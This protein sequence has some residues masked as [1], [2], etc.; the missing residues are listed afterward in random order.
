V[1]RVLAQKAVRRLRATQGPLQEFYRR[2]N[3]AWN[4]RD[5]NVIVQLFAEG[6]TYSNPHAGLESIG[7]WA[8]AVWAR[9][10]RLARHGALR[11]HPRQRR[12]CGIRGSDR[13]IGFRPRQGSNLDCPQD[14][15]KQAEPHARDESAKK[16]DIKPPCSNPRT[17][18]GILGNIQVWATLE[19]P[20]CRIAL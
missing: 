14:F 9:S 16:S 7:N 20:K 15:P 1:R 12:Y 5:A 6:G 8:K 11:H 3:K 18:N 19:H 4:G 13:R 17:S 2:Y 10:A